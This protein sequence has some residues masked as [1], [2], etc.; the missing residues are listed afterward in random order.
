M[1]ISKSKLIEQVIKQVEHLPTL[2]QIIM[3]VL[4]MA[5]SPNIN[6]LELAKA[7]DQSLAAKVLKVANSAYYGG[8][9]SRSVNSIPHAIVIIGFDAVKEIILTTSFFHTF[10]DAQDVEALQPLW[11]HSMDCALIAKRLSWIYRLEE[12]DEVYFAGLIHDIGKLVIQQYFPKQYKAIE[13]EKEKGVEDLS[14][15]T[16]ILGLTHAEIGGKMCEHW[17]F[18]ENMVDAITH[19]HDEKWLV[20]E[21]LGR[22]LYNADRY[23]RGRL[24]FPG[25]LNV[26]SQAGMSYPA[27]WDSDDLENVEEI[28]KGEI[29]KSHK[30]FNFTKDFK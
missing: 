3:R 5:E 19:H 4:S 20:D 11:Q 10:S 12:L 28:L 29:E 13:Q 27:T 2:P 16:E 17:S 15:E 14:A 9:L 30:M 22:I 25:L 6:A 18:P 24:D 21:K 23:V 7:M 8:R 26:F 1:P